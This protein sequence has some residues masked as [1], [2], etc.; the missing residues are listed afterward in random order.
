MF[1]VFVLLEPRGGGWGVGGPSAASS[2]APPSSWGRSPEVLWRPLWAPQ[3]SGPACP[4]DVLFPAFQKEWVTVPCPLLLSVLPWVLPAQS[5]TRQAPP[6][7][8]APE[9][10]CILLVI[11][12]KTPLHEEHPRP[13]ATFSFPA[14][15]AGPLSLSARNS[16]RARPA[17]GGH[18]LPPCRPRHFPRS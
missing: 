2:P 15:S 1:P 4:V 7:S 5:L 6:S 12:D 11:C 8:L 3:D 9:A 16:Q 17:C 14:S 13:S 18:G 10:C